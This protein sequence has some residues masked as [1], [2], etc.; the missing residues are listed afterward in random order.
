M[1]KATVVNSSREL[2][3]RDRIKFT[4]TENAIKL[5]EATANGKHLIISPVDY[6]ELHIECDKS[7]KGEYPLFLV[8]DKNGDKYVTGSENFYNTFR[9]IF[10]NMKADGEEFELDI[11]ARESKNYKGKFFITCSL[12]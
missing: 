5:D 12:V 6:V 11:Y 3:A 1:Y 2:T 9:D 8:I 4:D 7:D 10:D